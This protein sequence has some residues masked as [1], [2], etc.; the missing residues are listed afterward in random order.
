MNR[1]KIIIVTR[2]CVEDIFENKFSM[3]KN[4]F[5]GIAYSQIT[6][7]WSR[8]KK[9]CFQCFQNRCM[10]LPRLYK[11][12]HIFACFVYE[13]EIL[14][15]RFRSVD[16]AQL[17]VCTLGVSIQNIFSLSATSKMNFN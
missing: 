14:Q 7:V 4:Y 10:S 9:P 13:T 6:Y 8:G 16:G 17:K 12:T 3:R 5:V 15:A 2:F 11:L 1:H